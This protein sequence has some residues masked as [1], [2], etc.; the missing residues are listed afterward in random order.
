VSYASALWLAGKYI[1]IG[2]QV[3]NLHSGATYDGTYRVESNLLRSIFN[4]HSLF[5]TILGLNVTCIM[6]E[7]GAYL[8]RVDDSSL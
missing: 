6:G 8:R 5:E 2:H 4:R 3:V 1:A 7:Y